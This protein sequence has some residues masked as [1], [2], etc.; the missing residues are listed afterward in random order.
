LLKEAGGMR[1][2]H[3]TEERFRMEEIGEEKESHE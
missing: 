2:R 1:L 3:L